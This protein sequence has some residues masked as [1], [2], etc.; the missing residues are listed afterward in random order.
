MEATERAPRASSADTEGDAVSDDLTYLFVQ[1]RRP[2]L[3]LMILALAILA[4]T[5]DGGNPSW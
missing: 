3:L 1:Y 4:Y 5:G 2:A